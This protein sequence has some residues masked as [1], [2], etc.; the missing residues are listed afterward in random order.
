MGQ[1]TGSELS[2]RCSRSSKSSMYLYLPEIISAVQ[3]E[4]FS[5]PPAASVEGGDA[6]LL[7]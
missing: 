4:N 3:S 7:H 5:V 6:G 2:M 1:H